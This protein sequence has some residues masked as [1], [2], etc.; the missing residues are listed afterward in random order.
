MHLD[1]LGALSPAPRY[2][3]CRRDGLL[4]H[5]DAAGPRATTPAASNIVAR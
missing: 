5:I 3:A 4:V 2:E 1:A